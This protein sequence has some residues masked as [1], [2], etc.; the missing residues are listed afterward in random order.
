MRIAQRS[1]NDPDG[2]T[3]SAPGETKPEKRAAPERKRAPEPSEKSELRLKEEKNTRKPP[4]KCTT[5]PQGKH[6]GDVRRRNPVL[7]HGTPW[8]SDPVFSVT[9]RKEK[10]GR[11]EARRRY[12]RKKV[13]KK[14]RR[15]RMIP[16]YHRSQLKR[17]PPG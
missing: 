3:T 2:E 7:A 6:S 9:K 16:A 1:L 10:K 11:T 12:E 13:E 14:T 8:S 5:N 4:A 17:Q 15:Q